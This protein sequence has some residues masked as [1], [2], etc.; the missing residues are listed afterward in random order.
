MELIKNIT[1]STFLIISITALVILIASQKQPETDNKD[2]VETT[3]VEINKVD[4]K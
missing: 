2:N 4:A 1:V 3:I